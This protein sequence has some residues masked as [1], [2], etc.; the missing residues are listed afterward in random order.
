MV[1]AALSA[2]Q[3]VLSF[4]SEAA[5][6]ALRE[7]MYKGCQHYRDASRGVQL[8]QH[9]AQILLEAF[10]QR[11]IEQSAAS[12]IHKLY[13]ACLVT[14]TVFGYHQFHLFKVLQVTIVGKVGV[15]F[16]CQLCFQQS[17]DK[18]QVIFVQ[19]AIF[20]CRCMMTAFCE[21]CFSG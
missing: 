10:A 16:F 12:H 8:R 3:A 11:Q 9:C 14:Y 15:S 6:Q 1:D 17:V 13:V 2:T 20:A 4:L 19:G 5:F 7:Q 18:V 21:H